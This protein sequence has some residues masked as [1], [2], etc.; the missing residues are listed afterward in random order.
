MGWIAWER[1]TCTVDCN[2]YPD[3]C[4]N[5]KLFRE[6]AQKM[7]D[8]GYLTRGYQYIN[9]DDCWSE[10]ERNPTTNKLVEN[11]E[12]FPEGIRNLSDHLHQLG[13][14]LG[15]YGNCGTA[16][17]AGYPAQLNSTTDLEG[18]Y[19]SEDANQLAA[20]QI[21]SFKFDGCNVDNTQAQLICPEMTKAIQQ[22]NRSI[23]ITCEWPFYMLSERLE[24]DFEITKQACNMWRY[25]EDVQDSWLSILSIVDFTIGKQI[26]ILKSHGPGAWF[27]P[28]QL[29]IGNFALSYHQA[30]AQLAIWSI[31][32]APLMM[33]ND[34]RNIS[35]QMGDLLKNERVIAIDQ[36]Q[37]GVFGLMVA[38]A[39]NGTLQAFVKPVEPIV[40]GCP[41]FAVVY[42]NR[43]TLGNYREMSFN[44][45]LLLSRIPF[46]LSAQRYAEL[47]P[48]DPRPGGPMSACDCKNRILNG[49]TRGFMASQLLVRPI[50]SPATNRP[51]IEEQ[52]IVYK[53]YDL[54]NDYQMESL[55]D[56]IPLNGILALHVPP[57]GVRMLKLVEQQWES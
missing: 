48:N 11:R 40:N 29:V 3:D 27:D 16:T 14:K 57:S 43:N 39:Q 38:S 7:A 54:F 8:D 15:I 47:Y 28:D 55:A 35:P 19:M 42:F 26:K 44:L 23:L 1:F 22:T 10:L 33:G 37:L 31:W 2:K 12:R 30:R 36:D 32:S 25:F 6:M 13:L 51:P 41:S 5:S 20:W 17:C 53:I 9:I 46:Q 52:S 34:L 45:R 18:N 24:P 50:N 21:D 56:T 4:V 49:M